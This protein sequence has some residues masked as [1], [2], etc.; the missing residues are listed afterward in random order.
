MVLY[1]FNPGRRYIFLV[2]RFRECIYL[3]G[4]AGIPLFLCLFNLAILLSFSGEH[5]AGCSGE[6]K[7]IVPLYRKNT[8]GGRSSHHHRFTQQLEIKIYI[9]TAFARQRERANV[10]FI[11]WNF[12][13][14]GRVTLA[15]CC[16][17]IDRFTIN[18]QRRSREAR[19]ER[20]KHESLPIS[21]TLCVVVVHIMELWRIQY[22]K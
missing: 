1:I 9:H 4:T 19:C 20:E 15:A 5:L 17:G 7:L 21:Y 10:L 3:C 13:E 16:D 12:R 11:N 2:C 14:E 8:F 6:I 22:T 18:R